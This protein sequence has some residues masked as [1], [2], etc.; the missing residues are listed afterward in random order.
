MVRQQ[1][2]YAKIYKE[3]VCYGFS[4]DLEL[5]K[6][7]NVKLE[8]VFRRINDTLWNVFVKLPAGEAFQ[9]CHFCKDYH[10][11]DDAPLTYIV[12]CALVNFAKE[13]QDKHDVESVIATKAFAMGQDN[14]Y[15]PN[16]Y[17]F[18]VSHGGQDAKA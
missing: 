3:R 16:E 1:D 10:I 11:P 18:N 15:K 8:F 5:S 4:Y 7:N 13:L 12:G 6:A 9:P 17:Y 14:V 2:L